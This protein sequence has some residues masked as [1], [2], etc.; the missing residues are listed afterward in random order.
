MRLS[1][2]L[3]AA[4]R[5]IFGSGL[6]L[7]ASPTIADA[8]VPKLT[9]IRAGG[10]A[11]CVDWLAS[12]GRDVALEQ[13]AYGYMSAIAATAQLSG[14]ADPLAPW[15]SEAIHAWLA[16]HCQAHPDEHLSVALIRL[17]FSELKK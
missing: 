9:V 7:L 12:D 16:G 15:D 4:L 13:W 17:I 8:Q 5:A 14:R 2:T 3:G 6:L 10:G 11:S 1:A